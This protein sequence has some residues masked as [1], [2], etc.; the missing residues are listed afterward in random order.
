[1]PSHNTRFRA[2]GLKVD[3]IG[4]DFAPD[5]ISSTKFSHFTCPHCLFLQVIWV[6]SNRMGVC[7]SSLLYKNVIVRVSLTAT[8]YL[9][10]TPSPAVSS[11]LQDAIIFKS[12]PS[13]AALGL[14]LQS[15][16]PKLRLSSFSAH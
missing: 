1:M 6:V 11:G 4:D 13:L 12:S 2:L 5:M 16:A 9:T 14:W 7:F 8:Q 3:T 10:K 15:Q